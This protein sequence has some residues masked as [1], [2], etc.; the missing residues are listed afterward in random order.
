M[1]AIRMATAAT[2]GTGV[3][4]GRGLAAGAGHSP[5]SLV[6]DRVP[7]LE[8]RRTLVLILHADRKPDVHEFRERGAVRGHPLHPAEDQAPAY[9][10]EFRERVP[11]S[12]QVGVVDDVQ[13][14][15]DVRDAPIVGVVQLTLHLALA[16]EREVALEHHI[17]RGRG[18]RRDGGR[19]RG[20]GYAGRRGGGWRLGSANNRG[21]LL[22]R[23][24]QGRDG[25]VAALDPFPRRAVQVGDDASLGDDGAVL[26]RHAVRQRGDGRHQIGDLTGLRAELIVVGV[27]LCPLPQTHK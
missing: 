21:L 17:N 5:K 2:L 6:V 19:G 16:L 18:C 13:G 4:W 27:V 25:V 24:V 15:G 10:E 14:P 12:A 7:Q 3:G 9:L 22:D 11:Q 23:R 1:A 26:H 8:V 20:G